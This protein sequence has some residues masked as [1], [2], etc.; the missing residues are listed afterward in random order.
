M[1]VTININ[2]LATVRLTSH[3]LKTFQENFEK[4]GLEWRDY[5]RIIS[6][7]DGRIRT[8]LW[9]LMNIFGPKIY[10]GCPAQFEKNN[11]ELTDN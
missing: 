4:L 5:L 1:K 2:D 11:I 10:M 3:G 6:L 7:P 9:S 8:E